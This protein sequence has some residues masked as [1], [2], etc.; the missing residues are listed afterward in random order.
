MKRAQNKN[1]CNLKGVKFSHLLLRVC[2]NTLGTF[3]SLP[4]I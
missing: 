3:L 1:L 4:R 2:H